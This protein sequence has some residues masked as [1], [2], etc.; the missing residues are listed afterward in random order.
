MSVT[1]DNQ[2][3]PA[4]RMGLVTVGDVLRHLH[5]RNR[6]VVQ[7]LLD[8]QAPD[9]S[10]IAELRKAPLTGRV[11]YV[12]TEDPSR[13]SREVIELVQA[14]LKEAESARELAV[15]ELHAHQYARG[16]E[17]LSRCLGAWQTA[18]EAIGR[19]AQLLRID[20]SRLQCKG[21][22]MQQFLSEFAA[23]LKR[24]REDLENRDFGAIADTLEYE[25][26]KANTDWTEALQAVMAVTK[27]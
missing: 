25:L 8:G 22:S 10:R 6:V 24:L 7:V 16:M 18:E 20:L 5:E 17:Q 15:A 13:L 23:R 19:V 3:L 11:L 12:E 9:L 27:G 1:I 14:Q 26:S 4:E 2:A 21:R